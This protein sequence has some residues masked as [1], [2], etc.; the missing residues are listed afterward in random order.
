MARTARSAADSGIYHVMHRGVNREIIYREDADNERFLATLA[1]VKRLSGCSVLGY[2]LMSNHF[3]LLLRTGGE[4]L[5]RLMHRLGVRYACWFNHK[6]G[7]VGHVFQNRFTSI[8]VEDDPYF[9]TLVGYIWNN[10][11]RAGIV[12]HPMD[13][14]WNSALRVSPSGSSITTSWRRCF[15]LRTR[16]STSPQVWFRI[17]RRSAVW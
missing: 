13:Y 16:R 12:T 10:P 9:V 8:P 1:V 5:G 17:R 11:V 14:G 6:Y 3:H 7:R 4:P 2:C 15:P